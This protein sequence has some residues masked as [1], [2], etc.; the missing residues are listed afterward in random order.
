MYE[1]ESHEYRGHTIRVF[2]DHDAENPRVDGEAFGTMSCEHRRYDLGDADAPGPDDMR[3][4]CPND[5][6][7]DYL[8][9]P[10]TRDRGDGRG[11]RFD[12]PGYM[13]C[14][15]CDGDGERIAPV[16]WAVAQGATVVLG[17]YLYDHSGITMSGSTLYRDGARVPGGNPFSC[18]WDS[19]M[20]GIMYAGPDD[21]RAWFGDDADT[22]DDAIESLLRSHLR[23]YDAFLRGDVQRYQIEGPVCEDSCGGFFPDENGSH[24]WMLADARAQVDHAIEWEAKQESGI[25]RMMRL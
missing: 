17:L 13:T 25:A 7:G 24:D 1:I 19:G 10:T 14:D 20:V 22:S 23:T 4:P 2:A 18:R 3:I 12:D 8:P 15:S 16:E 21:M 5:C 6:E 9:V 11:Y